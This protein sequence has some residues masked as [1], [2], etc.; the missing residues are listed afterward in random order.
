MMNLGNRIRILRALNGLSQDALG[1]F[2][3]IDTN[4][5]AII[6]YE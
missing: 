1:N 6:A 5:I 4:R 3:G 2:A